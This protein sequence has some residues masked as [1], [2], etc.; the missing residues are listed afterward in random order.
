M[1]TEFKTATLRPGA[2]VNSD[3]VCYRIWA[4]DESRMDVVV[5]RDG[6]DHT[7]ALERQPDG[8]WET[9]DA[10]G[11]AGDRYRFRLANGTLVPDVASRFQ[12]LGVHGPSECIDP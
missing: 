8:F 6:A 11:R 4:P 5:T 1:N 12:P 10:R 9:T 7:L 2:H 3:G